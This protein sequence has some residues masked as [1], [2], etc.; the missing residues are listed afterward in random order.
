[1][2]IAQRKFEVKDYWSPDIYNPWAWS[3]EDNS[4]FYL[5]EMT[6]GIKGENKGIFI[7]LLLQHLKV[8]LN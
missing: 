2:K 4:V 7:R 6:I 3:P 8:Y 1:M 5:L